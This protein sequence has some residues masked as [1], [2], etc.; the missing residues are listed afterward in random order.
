VV[1]GTKYAVGFDLFKTAT[2]AAN[3]QPF[4]ITGSLDSIPVTIA[5]AASLPTATWEHFGAV[6]TPTVSGPVD[7]SFHFVVPGPGSGQDVI[8]DLVYVVTP[9]VGV[10]EPVSLALLGVGL[11]AL[12]LLRRKRV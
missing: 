10:P 2:G 7:F 3:P 11:G 8:A 6:I 4:T 12:G 9:P 5:Q 1:A